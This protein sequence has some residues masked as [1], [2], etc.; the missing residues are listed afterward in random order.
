[1]LIKQ[2][3]KVRLTELDV[4][5]KLDTVIKTVNSLTVNIS[6]KYKSDGIVKTLSIEH[7]PNYIYIVKEYICISY[8]LLS[9]WW[10][11]KTVFRKKL[12]F[13]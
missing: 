10:K 5:E 12:Q 13:T 7:T 11:S 2:Y 4:L 9:S 3:K 6:Y 8:F 1:M